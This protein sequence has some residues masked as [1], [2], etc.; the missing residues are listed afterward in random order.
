MGRGVNLIQQVRVANTIFRPH[1]WGTR[2]ALELLHQLAHGFPLIIPDL[3]RRRDY[4][5]KPPKE[6]FIR[7]I[8]LETFLPFMTFPMVPWY[9]DNEVSLEFVYY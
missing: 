3:I 8:Q 4:R 1:N 2:T 7:W 9:Y 6:R 5:K